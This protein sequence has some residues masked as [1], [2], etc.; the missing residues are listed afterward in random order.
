MTNL[1]DINVIVGQEVLAGEPIGRMDSNKSE[2]YMEVRRGDKAVDPA[3]IF[4][5]SN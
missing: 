1:G 3:R 5:E 2:M 4:K